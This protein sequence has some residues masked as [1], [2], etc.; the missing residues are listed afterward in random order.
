M[1]T[2][3]K[4]KKE[5]ERLQG[6]LQW[7]KSFAGGRVV[8]Q[9]LLTIS[10]MASTGRK[11]ERLS[12]AEL[13]ALRFLKD[14]VIGAPPTK[15]RSTR[16]ATWFVFSDGAC[17]GAIK[18]SVGAVL[19]SPCGIA[20]GFFAE[21]VPKQ[22]MGHSFLSSSQHQSSNLSCSRCG[23][24]SLSGRD[25]LAILSLFFTCITKQQREP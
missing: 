22:W 8:Q 14:R 23:S 7:F 9:S 6:R 2:T 10:K 19:V 18:E 17:E 5:A 20:C 12:Q 15:I 4:S 13:S 21:T 24:R 1:P 3:K 16:M 11:S 25:T